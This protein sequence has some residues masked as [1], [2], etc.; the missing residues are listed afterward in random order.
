[1]PTTPKPSKRRDGQI[2]CKNCPE[3]FTPRA[4]GG[5]PQLFCSESCRKQFNHN[6]AAFGKLRDKL[7]EYI[8]D[9]VRRQVAE[10]LLKRVELLERLVENLRRDFETL[11]V[12]LDAPRVSR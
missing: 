7:P 4:K 1:M 8:H 6:G 10:P 12:G 5:S 11:A 3:W 9:E 2:L